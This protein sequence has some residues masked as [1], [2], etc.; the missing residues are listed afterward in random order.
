MPEM[1]LNQPAALGKSGFIYSACLTFTKIKK[2]IQKFMQAE[3]TRYTYQNEVDKG[4]FQRE[5]AYGR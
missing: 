3:G 2:R 5:M 4:S 1:R